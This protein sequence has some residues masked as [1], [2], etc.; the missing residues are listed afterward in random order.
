[1]TRYESLADELAGL[2][3]SGV[4]RPGDRLPST[5]SVA[6]SRRLSV[7][8]VTQAYYLL[9]DRGLVSARPRNARPQDSPVQSLAL[10]RVRV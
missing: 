9:E 4:L 3:E 6:A 8:T 5:R 7:A 1:M 10:L 2:V